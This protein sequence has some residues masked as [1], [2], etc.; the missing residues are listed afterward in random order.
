MSYNRNQTANIYEAYFIYEWI[1]YVHCSACTEWSQPLGGI[2]A[3]GMAIWLTNLI[4][5]FSPSFWAFQSSSCCRSCLSSSDLVVCLSKGR[6][7]ATAVA[8]ATNSGLR[9]LLQK[10]N[11]ENKWETEAWLQ[12]KVKIDFLG[13]KLLVIRKVPFNF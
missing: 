11:M 10:E 2:R 9:D 4:L 3:T 8:A 12:W 1:Y 7:S 5:G 6:E 13:K